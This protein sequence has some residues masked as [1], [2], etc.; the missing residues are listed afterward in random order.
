M[1]HTISIKIEAFWAP[2]P[3]TKNH[4]TF[5]SRIVQD[6]NKNFFVPASTAISPRAVTTLIRR[7]AAGPPPRRSQSYRP[8][9]PA[10]SRPPAL[11]RVLHCTA[12][13]GRRET[14]RGRRYGPGERTD[15]AASL[16]IL[17]FWWIGQI[18]YKNRV[19]FFLN[20]IDTYMKLKRL[21][22]V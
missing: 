5:F 7:A 18:Y 10:P 1:T 22:T 20:Q 17:F 15:P 9:S 3:Q 6:N 21:W 12:V 4:F 11:S 16:L 14:P 19:S 13:R 2:E 8:P